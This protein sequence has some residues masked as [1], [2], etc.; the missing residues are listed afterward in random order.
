MPNENEKRITTE[1]MDSKK[2]RAFPW[3]KVGAL[4]S[5][6]A[7]LILVLGGYSTYGYL[8]K[9]YAKLNLAVNDLQIGQKQN[10]ND[11]LQKNL[12]LA[13]QS[14]QQLQIDFKEM[15]QA[16]NVATQ[17]QQGN[18][19]TLE[20]AQAHYYV[21]LANTQLQYADNITLA[22]ALLK[23]ADDNIH[24]LADPKF[25]ETR[26]ALAQDIANLQSVPLVDVTGLY[27]RLTA[28]NNQIDRLPLPNKLLNADTQATHL[29]VD[30]DQVWWKKG[31]QTTWQA[32]QKIVV[33]RYNQNE[34][35]PLVTPDQ[36]QF[37]Y[38][39]LHA[40]VAEAIWALLHQQSIIY[41]T[42][43]QQTISWVKEYFVP[44]SPITQAVI[45]ELNQLQAIDIH[46]KKREIIDS[47][48][49]LDNITDKHSV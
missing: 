38:Q 28:L 44:D 8:E 36:Q 3:G 34:T 48:Q 29:N 12:D 1:E 30:Q 4:F 6:V 14:I 10:H 39:N 32:L 9:S 13:L 17:T 31:L 24:Q 47:L 41:Q 46:P 26:K 42:S 27:M 11:D 18:K 37:L 16:L 35:L 22:I 15:Q 40:R 21:T 49:A 5:I 45:T 43:L 2:V 19:N 33:V 20:V 23:L 25:D 7:I